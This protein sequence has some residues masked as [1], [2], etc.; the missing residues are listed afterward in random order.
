MMPILRSHDIIYYKVTSFLKCGVD[1]IIIIQKNNN[2]FTHRIVY[3]TSKYLITKGDN[4]II[5][6]GKIYPSQIIGRVHKIKRDGKVYKIK[7][8]YLLQS[9]HYFQEIFK[10]KQRFDDLGVDFIFLKGLPLHLFFEK[11]HPK[12]IY[13]DCDLLINKNDW[14]K[15]HERME[16]FGFR[17]IETSYS[18]IHKIL[19]NKPT[20]LLYVKNVNDVPVVFDI[21]LEAGFLMNQ[22]GKLNAF[23]P[24]S[25]ID[26]MTENLLDEKKLVEIQDQYFP[27]P[28]PA[29]LVI[30]LS[31]HF[32]H[33]NY[34][35][36]HMIDFL[37]KIVKRYQKNHD[38]LKEIKDKIILYRLQNFVYPVFLLL[39]K[40]YTCHLP[41]GLLGSIKP[42]NKRLSYIKKNILTVNIFD[43]EPRIRG[44]INRFK[45]LFFLSPNPLY[46]R[47][48]IV[49]N[50]QVIY[51]VFWVITLWVRRSLIK[52]FKSS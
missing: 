47:L 23:Y 44:G 1:N 14:K 4:N 9:A 50:L 20:E 28:S 21:H 31:L 24:Q 32:F 35:G 33:H 39:E 19:K 43:E 51:S 6:D 41:K 5:S 10:I 46:E 30:Y 15:V 22:L 13:N 40:Y 52:A 7:S 8:I 49:F 17:R 26:K 38:I 34:R 2:V 37:S 3:K 25:L 48:L 16:R 11:S 27:I 36:W 18:K 45:N 29:N 42:D 12:R